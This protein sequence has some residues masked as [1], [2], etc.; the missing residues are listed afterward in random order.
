MQKVAAALQGVAASVKILELPNPRNVKGY[1]VS[2]FITDQGNPT[3]R[4]K[5]LSLMADGLAEWTPPAE[6]E[7]TTDNPSGFQFIHNAD[8]L[9]DLKPIEWRIRDIFPDYALYYN[10]GDP[11][12][13]RLSSSLTGFYVSLPAST[14]TAT[15]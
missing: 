4:Q 3:Q 13:S 5:K 12:T 6:P 11:A 9:A 1:D 7:K 14:T 2:D 8:I 10:F 15:R